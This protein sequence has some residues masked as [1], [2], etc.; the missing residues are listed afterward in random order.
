VLIG[1][2]CGPGARTIQD[3]GLANRKVSLP[4]KSVGDLVGQDGIKV[5]GRDPLRKKSKDKCRGPSRACGRTYV[6]MTAFIRA[7]PF[8]EL[9]VR[10]TALRGVEIVFGLKP[11]ADPSG[12]RS[13]GMA[14]PSIGGGFR[15]FAYC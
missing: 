8:D 7:F 2:L 9:R 3:D 15:L 12:E 5:G 6:Q 13:C 11:L 4:P 14:L 10:M 1:T